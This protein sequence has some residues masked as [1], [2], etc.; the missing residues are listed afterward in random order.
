MGSRFQAASVIPVVEIDD[1]DHAEPLAEALLSGGINIVEVTLRTPAAERAIARIA[2]AFPDMSIGAGTV[3]NRRQAE[4]VIHA[5][6]HFGAS[7]GLNP[8]IVKL[9]E[10]HEL[11]FLPGVVTPTEVE[12]ARS[13]GCHYLKFFPAEAAG[14]AA[15]LRALSGP[16]SHSGVKFCATGGITLENMVDDLA[17]SLVNA[18]GGSWIAGRWQIANREWNA[19]ARQARQAMDRLSELETFDQ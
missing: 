9:F 16:Y 15:Y 8:E 14:G 1:A 17:V 18:I 2:A 7:P 6:A 19:I 5:G 4:S 12:S 3:L 10:R 13:L 11:P